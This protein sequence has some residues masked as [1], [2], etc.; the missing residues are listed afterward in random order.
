MLVSDIQREN[1]EW[2]WK[3]RLALGKLTILDGDPGLGKSTLY[4]DIAARITTGMPWPDA[5]VDSNTIERQPGDVV[6]VTCEDG[7]GDTIRPRL[8]EA[9]ADLEK[10]RVIQTVR[11]I[12]DK[13]ELQEHIP[14]LPD[15][16]HYIEKAIK[17]SSA[18]FLVIDPLFAHLAGNVNSYRDQ[19][20]R[21][22]L[23]PLAKMAEDNGVAVLVVRHLNKALGGSALYRGGGSIGIIG[24]ARLA[25]LLGR[26]PENKEA[27]VLA[28]TKSNISK[29]TSSLALRVI[30]SEN[31]KDVGVI[32]WEGDSSY[33][34]SDLISPDKPR[35]SPAL[36][37]A[38]E[39]LD[40]ELQNGLPHLVS[41]IKANAKAAG[42]SDK[43]LQRAKGKLKVKSVQPSGPGNPWYWKLPANQDEKQDDNNEA[44]IPPDGQIHEIDHL[45]DVHV[46]KTNK[47]GLNS[48]KN[49]NPQDSH[50]LANTQ[51]T[52]P[53]DHLVNEEEKEYI[54]N[55]SR[56]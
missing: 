44:I 39:W 40:K 42:I 6:I 25:M 27:L 36:T 45:A 51:Q 49:A 2:L 3:G 30:S 21:R 29:H 32:Q 35:K 53:L 20:V 34:A 55:L 31:D 7:I 47:N 43:T 14:V 38:V 56:K 33:E 8:E 9:G 52:E 11:S 15:D 37:K 23:S 4:C 13:G 48:T 16:L 24:Q 19:D 1:I 46:Q 12:N 17:Q 50:Q 18:S 54:N 10:C 5:I 22:A 26:N 28:P 41:D